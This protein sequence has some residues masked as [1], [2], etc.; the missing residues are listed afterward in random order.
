M[1]EVQGA[2]REMDAISEEE[3]IPTG[4]PILVVGVTDDGALIVQPFKPP[5][6]VKLPAMLLA[7]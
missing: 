6:P 1:V 7:M 5:V 2:L 4:Q 3:A